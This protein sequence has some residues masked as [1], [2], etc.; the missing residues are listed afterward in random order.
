MIHDRSPFTHLDERAKRAV[1]LARRKAEG[2]HSE[3][4]APEHI[5]L[6]LIAVRRGLAARA[7]ANLSGSCARAEDA[8]AGTLL[9]GRRSSPSHIPFTSATEE[10][11]VGAAEQ[12]RLLGDEHI[13]TEH[14]LLG[15]LCAADNTAVCGLRELGVTYDTARAE[16]GRLRADG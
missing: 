7:V 13:G 10:I 14:L 2:G 5:L 8:I 15:L 3:F 16:V 12:A 1:E 11:M 9:P 6:A 4:I